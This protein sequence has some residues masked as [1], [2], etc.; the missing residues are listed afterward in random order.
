VNDDDRTP[1]VSHAVVA[2]GSED[3]LRELA[4]AAA[5]DDQ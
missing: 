5:A 4:A 3:E 1:R 2:D